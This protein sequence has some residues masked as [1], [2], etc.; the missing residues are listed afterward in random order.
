MAWFDEPALAYQRLTMAIGILALVVEMV[1]AVLL[2][3]GKAGAGI[4]GALGGAAA[5]GTVR[6]I[7]G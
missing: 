2:M 5:A 6:F 1:L 3:P 4:G 7:G